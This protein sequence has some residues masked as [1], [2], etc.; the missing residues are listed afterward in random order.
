M[1]VDPAPHALVQHRRILIADA[2]A[3]PS[4]KPIRKKNY[5]T[6]TQRKR[7]TEVNFFKKKLKTKRSSMESKGDLKSKSN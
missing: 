7:I 5:V 1:N 2:H 3:C 4:S 6:K